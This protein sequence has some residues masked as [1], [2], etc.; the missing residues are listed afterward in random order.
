MRWQFVNQTNA[1]HEESLREY[2]AGT[3]V[4]EDYFS[5]PIAPGP[6]GPGSLTASS[7]AQWGYG[8]ISLNL[9]PLRIGNGYHYLAQPPQ[10]TIRYPRDGEF[11]TLRVQVTDS[12]GNSID[13][14]ITRAW[15]VERR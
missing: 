15:K 8:Y 1:L 5:A 6:V 14:T 10:S 4:T 7:Y 11:V 9:S 13:Q 2:A 12:A 3:R